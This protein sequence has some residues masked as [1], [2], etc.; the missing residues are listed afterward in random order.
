MPTAP[1]IKEYEQALERIREMPIEERVQYK[2]LIKDIRFF[3]QKGEQRR[4]LYK[5]LSLMV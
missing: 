1:I 2:A 5:L 4:R 3:S